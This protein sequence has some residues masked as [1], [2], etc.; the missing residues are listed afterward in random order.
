MEEDA[1]RLRLETK[2]GFDRVRRE[3]ADRCNTD[4]AVQRVENENFSND[5]EEIRQRLLLTDEMRLVLMF[6]DKFPTTGY[7]DALPFLVPLEKEG[8]SIDVL[9][10]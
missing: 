10:L 2:L 6:E 5:P 3:V 1:K 8:S 7:I 9:S 4:Y